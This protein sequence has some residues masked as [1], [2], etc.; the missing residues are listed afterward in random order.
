MQGD[1]FLPLDPEIEDGDCGGGFEDGGDAAH[2]GGV[3]AT[4][5]FQLCVASLAIDGVLFFP[6]RGG[7]LD[8][9][10]DFDGVSRGDAAEDSAGVVACGTQVAVFFY[11]GVVVLAAF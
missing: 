6:D 11:I 10:G 5:Y 4:F 1:F 2:E 3:V 8:G 9:D 7:G